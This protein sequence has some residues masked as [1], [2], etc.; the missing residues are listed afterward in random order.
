MTQHSHEFYYQFILFWWLQRDFDC[1][2]QIIKEKTLHFLHHWW[3]RYHSRKN[4]WAVNLMS[5]LNSWF[6]QLHCVQ[7]RFAVHFHSLKV[8]LQM[9]KH[10]SLIVHSLSLTDWWSER[11]SK[12]KCWKISL[13]LLLIHAERLIQMIVHDQVCW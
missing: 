1:S 11:M 4:N 6:T 7:S 8:S 3:W 9:T 2:L 13:F 10:F 12:S 5:I